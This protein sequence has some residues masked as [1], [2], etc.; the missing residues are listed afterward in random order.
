MY[1]AIIISGLTAAVVRARRGIS[2][3]LIVSF[4]ALTSRLLIIC[5]V[6]RTASID[7][8]VKENR[9]L[10]TIQSFAFIYTGYLSSSLHERAVIEVDADFNVAVV[11]RSHLPKIPSARRLR[12]SLFRDSARQSQKP[13]CDALAKVD[14]F[15]I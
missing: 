15:I 5:D 8:A 11:N 1:R 2:H 14:T 13:D 9:H 12:L 7:F 6:E 3:S 10:R 4:A